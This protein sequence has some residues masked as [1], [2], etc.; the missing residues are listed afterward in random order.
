MLFRSDTLWRRSEEIYASKK[1]AFE[2]GDEA[3]AQ[4][5]GEGKDLMSILCTFFDKRST[6]CMSK[7]TTAMCY[8]A[9]EHE[10]CR[11]R[12]ASRRGAAG[13]DV[14]R[15]FV[16]SLG[17]KG[18]HVRSSR[19]FIFAAMD[20]TSNALAVILDLLAQHP[21]VQDKLRQEIIE[22]SKGEDMG[23]DTLV[24]LP[25]LDAVCRETLRLYVCRLTA[26]S[27]NC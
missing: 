22:A 9:S 11:A 14:V 3:V 25:Y 15:S 12:Q 8:S 27:Q 23:Y 6:M 7:L 16:D 24:S 20:T 21:E 4:Q 5:I 13:A 2:Q 26:Q 17:S 10:R 18:S 19:T 1:Q